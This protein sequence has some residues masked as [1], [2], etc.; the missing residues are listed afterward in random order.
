MLNIIAS[1]APKDCKMQRQAPGIEAAN[2]SL[3]N[4]KINQPRPA[5]MH[6]C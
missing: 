4:Q 2:F 1:P 3:E 6:C 5:A